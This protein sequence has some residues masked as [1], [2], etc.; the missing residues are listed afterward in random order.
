MFHQSSRLLVCQMQCSGALEWGLVQT[1]S[2]QSR[3]E[4]G[5]VLSP[6]LFAVYM[7]GLICKLESCG[8]GCVVHGRFIG[9]IMYADDIILLAQS[10]SAMQRMLDLC[11]SEV[12]ELD[13]KFNV[14]KSVALR[15]GPRWSSS[16]AALML[17][18]SE[19]KYVDSC[20]Y[21]GV[22][23]NSG[24]GFACSYEHLKLKFYSSFNAVYARSKAADSEIVTVE[25]LKSFCLPLVTYGLEVTRPTKATV[26]MIDNMI[27]RAVYKIFKVRDKSDRNEIR[28]YVGLQGMRELCA[29]RQLKFLRSLSY[30][31]NAIL[32]VASVVL[33]EECS[34]LLSSFG[35]DVD[36]NCSVASLYKLVLT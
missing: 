16:C 22:Y 11:S 8:Y 3:S 26:T 21:L 5:G 31:D 20:K 19:L 14:N 4:T 35:V 30:L 13:L 24:V 10:S 28:K 23:I 15:V 27:D 12:N 29:F 34:E 9:C 17:G 33:H 32:K 18:A 2:S 1:V 6:L 36:L 7:D 25:L